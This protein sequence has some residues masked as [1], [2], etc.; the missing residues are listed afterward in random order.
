MI[1]QIVVAT[2]NKNKL[3]EIRSVLEPTISTQP[4]PA[5]VPEVEETGSTYEENA[6]LKA[7]AVA[8]YVKQAAAADDTGFEVDALDGAPGLYSARF[9][10]KGHDDALNRQKLVEVMADVPVERRTARYR[11][12]VVARLVD[13][14]E[15]VVEGVC[16]GT[17]PT[18]QRGTGGFGYDAVFV[19]AE[20]DGRT[21]AEMNEE[22][23]NA[24]SHRARAFR[25]LRERLTS[26]RFRQ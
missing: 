3:K 1:T 7:V 12:V 25:A 2:R 9:A 8:D 19:P 14:H 18:Q 16:E 20:G 13:G 6:R 11:T 10:G 24:I 21:F 23:K 5:E 17:V 4:C 15:I 22:E 26:E